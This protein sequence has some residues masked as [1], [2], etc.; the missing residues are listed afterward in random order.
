MSI[1]PRVDTETNWS[2]VNPTLDL[3]TI[4]ISSDKTATGTGSNVVYYY[5]YANGV[6]TWKA[7]LY[8]GVTDLP[9]LSLTADGEISVGVTVER[10]YSGYSGTVGPQGTSGYSGAVGTGTSGYSGAVGTSGYSGNS[11]VSG[12]SG[13]V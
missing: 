10:G 7:L 6:N 12:Y 9:A 5:K 11:G 1:T 3:G 4:C 2:S 8:V 13:A